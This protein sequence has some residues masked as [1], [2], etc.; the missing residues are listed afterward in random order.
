MARSRALR[1]FFTAGGTG[2]S[3]SR[4]R[5]RPGRVRED[6]E[7]GQP[8][9]AYR[10]DRP[11]ERGPV[12][13]REAYDHVGRQVE[14]REPLDRAQ[15]PVDRV[16]PAHRAQHV[17]VARLERHVQVRPDR[18]RL[19]ECRNQVVVTWLISIDESRS[20]STPSTA[21]ASRIRRARV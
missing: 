12:L 18:R 10:L 13:G 21:P 4:E 14:V 11:L 1:S 3:V 2:S 16:A 7:L 17:V 6:M 20:R 5:A 15:V 9:R 8:G 19:A